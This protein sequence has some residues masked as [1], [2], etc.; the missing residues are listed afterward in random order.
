MK[1]LQ[2]LSVLLVG[3]SLG[4]CMITQSNSTGFGSDSMARSIP[5]RINDG[6]IELTA[7]RNLSTI[8]GINQN[9]IRV[10]IDSFRREVLLTGEVPSETVK[11]EIARMVESM[12][13]VE[14][15]YNYLTITPTPK[16]QSHTVHENYLRSKIVSRLLTNR[17]VKAS[18]YKIIVRDRTAYIMGFLTQEQQSYILDAIKST[19]GMAA[20]V[21][22]TTLVSEVDDFVP[23]NDAQPMP[24][25]QQNEYADAV[26]E[27]PQELHMPD[28]QNMPPNVKPRLHVPIVEH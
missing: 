28:A 24:A 2:L 25:S 17:A 9:N 21:P 23:M 22:L 15:V 5:E 1:K 27:D 26:S 18:Q 4:G 14:K 12:K 6:S 19:S 3:V 10:S 7:R 16:S 11:F 8:Q 20:A 13:D